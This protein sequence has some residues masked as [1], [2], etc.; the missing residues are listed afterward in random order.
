VRAVCKRGNSPCK[1]TDLSTINNQQNQSIII[2]KRLLSRKRT[3]VLCCATCIIRTAFANSFFRQPFIRFLQE[4]VGK[5]MHS[6]SNNTAPDGSV[7]AD[8]GIVPDT[9]LLDEL[10][11]FYDTTATHPDEYDTDDYDYDDHDDSDPDPEDDARRSP[12]ANNSSSASTMDSNRRQ[13]INVQQQLQQPLVYR[14]YGR[15]R[16]YGAI[17]LVLIGPNVDHLKRVGEELASRGFLVLCCERLQPSTLQQQQKHAVAANAS[18]TLIETLLDALRWQQVVLV[19]CDQE[20]LVVVHAAMQLAPRRVRGVVLCGNVQAVAAH[21]RVEEE[22]RQLEQTLQQQQ[23]Q[24]QQRSLDTMLRDKLQCPF[25]IIHDSDRSDQHQQTATDRDATKQQQQKY[26]ILGG[27]AAPHRRRPEHFAWVLTRFVEEQ[28]APSL[29]MTVPRR[30][31]GALIQQHQQEDA[32]STRMQTIVSPFSF[33]VCGRV[34][35]TIVFYAVCLR[36]ALFQLENIR[37]GI[38]TISSLRRK[39]TTAIGSFVS[40]FVITKAREMDDDE[41][42][43]VKIAKSKLEEDDESNNKG[44][45]RVHE[46]EASDS[47][48]EIDIEGEST[49]ETGDD[50]DT[51]ENDEDDQTRRFRPLFFLDTVVA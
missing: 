44:K 43:D 30:Q 48:D 12:R 29:A 4:S 28:M 20:G 38:H 46:K 36:V 10:P 41:A 27:G 32:F 11:A 42:A 2:M 26:S 19:G 51:D 24:Q 50:S 7:P 23:Q 13:P 21:L 15:S 47:D 39:I 49:T 35:A 9:A 6:S 16:A 37:F 5:V 40:L 8:T 25:A 3:L 14:L 17:P 33:T 31:T 34:I 22:A 18:A 45:D 1:Y